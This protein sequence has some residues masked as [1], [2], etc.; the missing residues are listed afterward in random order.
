MDLNYFDE[1]N[2]SL[3]Q[4][5]PRWLNKELILRK[6]LTGIING[7]YDIEELGSHGRSHPDKT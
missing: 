7:H 3:S 5:S 1:I 6:H 4:N 2:S